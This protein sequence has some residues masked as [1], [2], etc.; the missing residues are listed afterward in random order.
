M[1]ISS[2]IMMARGRRGAGRAKWDLR[3]GVP[4][5]SQQVR[6]QAVIPFP[7]SAHRRCGSPGLLIGNSVGLP[8]TCN[9]AL[10]SDRS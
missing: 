9:P 8:A 1:W 4:G 2:M 3:F 5:D 10:N 7:D 6:L